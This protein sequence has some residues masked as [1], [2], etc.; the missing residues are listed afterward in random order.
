[1]DPNDHDR[2]VP[3]RSIGEL[4][5]EGPTLARGYLADPEKT[6]TVYIN[7]P[8][9]DNQNGVSRR[10]YKTGDLSSTPMMGRCTLLVVSICK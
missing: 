9:W 8:L 5:I 3:I 1:M 6:Q 4:V 10:F 7:N 2:L